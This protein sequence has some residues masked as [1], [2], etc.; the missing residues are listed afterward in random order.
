MKVCVCVRTRACVHVCVC[1]CM[2][3]QTYGCVHVPLTYTQNF[4][5]CDHSHVSHSQHST[6]SLIN[7]HAHTYIHTNTDVPHLAV[8]MVITAPNNYHGKC[9]ITMG[10]GVVITMG[11]GVVRSITMGWLLP[12]FLP[13]GRVIEVVITSLTNQLPGNLASLHTHTQIHT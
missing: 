11:N 3:V 6:H 9:I 1:V 5:D 2:C 13:R 10:S 8:I 12:I 7:A 4:C